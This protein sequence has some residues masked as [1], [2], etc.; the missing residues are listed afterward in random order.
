MRDTAAREMVVA[1]RTG[2]S[3]LWL[4]S[5][6]TWRQ[7][8]E[9]IV[10]NLLGRHALLSIAYHH[11]LDNYGTYQRLLVLFCMFHTFLA[12]NA[13]FFGGKGQSVAQDLVITFYTSL[14]VTPIGIIFPKL[15]QRAETMRLD[16]IRAQRAFGDARVK[17][18]C[19]KSRLLA[20]F[21]HLFCM[22]WKAGAILVTLVYGMQFD[23]DKRE[24]GSTLRAGG[25]SVSGR[26][27]IACLLSMTQNFLVNWPVI[28]MVMITL[29]TLL[30]RRRV[31]NELRAKAERD[32][33]E[34]AA[35]EAARSARG[36][37]GGDDGF[38]PLDEHEIADLDDGSWTRGSALP[39]SSSRALPAIELHSPTQHRS[40][41]DM[42]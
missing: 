2:A 11:P 15:Y 9:N 28:G 20:M 5:R 22:L 32:A 13:S 41:H 31:E 16:E 17:T 10:N 42:A 6:A 35:D 37:S 21:A 36:G 24:L 1:Q 27:L 12:V 18:C 3:C 26:W 34:A 40:I 30:A 25:M 14:F 7:V 39:D 23:L 4:T 8:R 19:P 33:E 29:H 38:D